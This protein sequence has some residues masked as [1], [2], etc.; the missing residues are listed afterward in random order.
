M[1]QPTKVLILSGD[2][3]VREP[4]CAVLL[5]EGFVVDQAP[6]V[7][8]A[9]ESATAHRP[10]D[11]VLVDATEETE[12]LHRFLD[13]AWRLAAKTVLLSSHRT[14]SV[15]REHP[16][17]VYVLEAPA[18]VPNLVSLAGWL[19]ERDPHS[20]PSLVL[21]PLSR[22]ATRRSSERHAS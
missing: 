12:E 17:V 9:L 11:I 1:D 3:R 16:S 19:A 6:D 2:A 5:R 14:P 10:P 21:R 7:P 8:S 22:V 13:E 18:V 20:R 4:A 15:L